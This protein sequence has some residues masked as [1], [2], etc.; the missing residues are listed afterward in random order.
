MLPPIKI[1]DFT[2]LLPGPLA[3]LYLADLGAEVIKVEDNK[4]GDYVRFMPP[5]LKNYSPLYLLLNRNKKSIAI[6]FYQ[7]EGQNI[8][9][10]LVQEADVVI[11]GFKPGTMKKWN[12]DYETLKSI[13]P[14]LI[15]IAITGYGSKGKWANRAGHDLNFLGYTGILHHLIKNEVTIPPI[16]IADVLGGSMHAV[17]A[18]LA[19][20]IHKLTYHEGQFLDIA[21]LDA[22]FAN[23][24]MLLSSFLAMRTELPPGSD[25]LTGGMPFYDVY[26]TKDNRYMVLAAIETKFWKL[27]CHTVQREDLLPKQ[28]VFGEDAKLVR[29]ELTQLFQSK[30]QNEWIEI[31]DPVDCCVTPVL[32]YTEALQLKHFQEKNTIFS[33]NHTTEG[34]F[35]SLNIP[36]FSEKIIRHDR[37]APAWGEH[38]QE[39][40][41]K[42]QFSEIQIDNLKQQK[43]IL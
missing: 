39:I 33:S 16:Q 14:D 34:N 32:N 29:H 2:R 26:P 9:H 42:L 17:I 6:D 5:L 11:E 35:K 30:T 10:R 24:H 43:I 22:T 1:L 8:I 41:E 40:L 20:Y 38:T 23:T 37:Q 3:T 7:E 27:F 21:M 15:Y 36:I 25:L 12:L 19:A 18:T 4:Q 28:F 31:F 13:K